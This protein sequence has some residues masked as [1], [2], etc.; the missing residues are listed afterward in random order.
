MADRIGLNDPRLGAAMA[1]IRRYGGDAEA[2]LAL[3]LRAETLSVE[4]KAW[5]GW[6]ESLGY[7]F[8]SAKGRRGGVLFKAMKQTDA[9]GGP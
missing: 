1:L 8:E 9:L 6:A 5:R 4:V 2:I 7:R 3:Y